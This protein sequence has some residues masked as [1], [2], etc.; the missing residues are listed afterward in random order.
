[1]LVTVV[2]VTTVTKVCILLANSVQLYF[3]EK[4]DI[5][6]LTNQ[7]AVTLYCQIRKQNKIR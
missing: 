4:C 2:T 3:A 5:N 6:C 1:M 7:F